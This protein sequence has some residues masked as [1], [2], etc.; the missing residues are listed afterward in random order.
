MAKVI[1]ECDTCNKAKAA[2]HKPYGELQPIPPP[3][4]AWKTIA[5]DFIVKLPL[6]K[7]PLTNAV[8][9]SILVITDKLTKYT[10]FLPYKEASNTEELAYTFLKTIVS[11]HGLPEQIIS[12]RDKLFTA[13]FWKSLIAQLGVK[14]KLLTAYHP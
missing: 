5:L 1:K 6:S 3:D 2:R 10:Y 8:Y 9:D 4:R 13:K 11:Q 12:D 14:H 7:E